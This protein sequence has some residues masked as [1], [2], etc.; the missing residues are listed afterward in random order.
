[1]CP[2]AVGHPGLAAAARAGRVW[3]SGR[4]AAPRRSQP[5]AP[6]SLPS[7]LLWFEAPSVELSQQAALPRPHAQACPGHP[8]R[9]GPGCWAR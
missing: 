9:E 4:L 6:R 3:V 7:S 8:Q 2:Q 5:A 1:M